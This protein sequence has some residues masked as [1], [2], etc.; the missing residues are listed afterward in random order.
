MLFFSKKIISGTH[1]SL[2]FNNSPIEQATTQ[3]LGLT[4][5]HKLTIQNHVNEKM[6][7]P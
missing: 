4:L 2:L 5:E 1:P 3:K 6:K 7:K